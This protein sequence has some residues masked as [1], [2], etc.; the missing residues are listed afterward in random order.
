MLKALGKP[1]LDVKLLLDNLNLLLVEFLLFVFRLLEEV[2]VNLHFPLKLL[3]DRLLFVI[4][5]SFV[6][7]ALQL[8][9]GRL[10]L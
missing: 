5:E 2:L 8:E 1:S 4:V 6:V 3:V 7:I 10:F 9:L